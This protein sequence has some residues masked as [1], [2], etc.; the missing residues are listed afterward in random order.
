MLPPLQFAPSSARARD[1]KRTRFDAVAEEMQ[2]APSSARAKDALVYDVTWRG[3]GRPPETFVAEVRARA[4]SQVIAAAAQRAKSTAY[5]APGTHPLI[6]VPYLSPASIDEVERLG[7]SAVDLCGNGVVQIPERWL[8]VRTGRPNQFR[9]SDPLRSAYR[10]VTSLV[11]RAFLVQP[12][13]A[14]VSDIHTFIVTRGGHITLATVSKALARLE[15]DL[16]IARQAK[17]LR[18]VQPDKLLDKLLASYQPPSVRTR[19]VTTSR[20]SELEM[21]H[22]LRAAAEAVAAR[23]VLTGVSSASRQTVFAAEPIT[24]FYCTCRPEDLADAAA[25]PCTSQR[26]FADLE[27]LQTDDERVYFDARAQEGR[28]LASPVQT[29]L[30]LASGEK[31]S[32]EVANELRARMLNEI[33]TLQTRGGHR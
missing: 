8:V 4:T 24:T 12:A 28:V 11:A 13:F 16:V 15:E 33:G 17:G 21:H 29:W 32:Q 22:R 7:I 3:G 23:V 2:F 31:R 18:L 26:H 30:E 25:I 1:A 9:G 20:L 6:I 19:L 14:R 10:G 27:L 5:D